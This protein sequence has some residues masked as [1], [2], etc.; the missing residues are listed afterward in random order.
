MT[1]HQNRL[2]GC[3]CQFLLTV[4]ALCRSATH[5]RSCLCTGLCLPAWTGCCCCRLDTC[6]HFLCQCARQ[7]THRSLCG[8][9]S[10]GKDLSSFFLS[11]T[12]LRLV[13]VTS[14]FTSFESPNSWCAMFWRVSLYHEVLITPSSSSPPPPPPLWPF[15]KRLAVVWLDKFCLLFSSSIRYHFFG[16]ITSHWF[17]NCSSANTIDSLI[18]SHLFS[19]HHLSTA[20]S[21]WRWIAV[22][23]LFSQQWPTR[24]F[25][26][27][28]PFARGH[29]QFFIF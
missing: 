23:N 29:L 6:C 4:C 22:F 19:V 10:T 27:C 13:F 26:V 1:I 18:A 21:R 5:S 14:L 8:A 20:R 16:S 7:S 9:A 25:S 17:D 15:Y 2:F 12:H 28:A 3:L 24:L 11:F